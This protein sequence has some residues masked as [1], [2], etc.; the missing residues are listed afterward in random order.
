MLGTSLLWTWTMAFT[1]LQIKSSKCL[2][3]LLVFLVWVLLFWSLSQEFGLVYI[4]DDDPLPLTPTRNSQCNRADRW[5]G[6][7]EPVITQHTE[8][9]MYVNNNLVREA[10]AWWPWPLTFD[11]W[12]WKWCPSHMWRGLPLCQF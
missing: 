11:F 6:R 8:S 10:K 12:R 5:N 7:H 2:C 1:Y 4:T 9:V 3:L